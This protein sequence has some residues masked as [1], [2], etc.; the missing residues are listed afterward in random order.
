MRVEDLQVR[1]KGESSENMRVRVE[2]CIT[3]QYE[4]FQG[5]SITCNANMPN[6]M[7]REYCDLSDADLHMLRRAM[8]E[9][10]LS[11]RAYDR[12]LKVSRTIADLDGVESIG[13]NHLLEAIQYRSM[14]RSFIL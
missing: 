13:K 12:I 10:S 7:I 9:L 6:K 2:K 1:E 14:D 3:I 11:A 5:N 8:N 4:R